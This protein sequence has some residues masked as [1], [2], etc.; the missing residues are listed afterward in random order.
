MIDL[1][2]QILIAVALDLLI[3]DP[4]WL[5]HPVK[6]IGRLA[7]WLES[8]SRRLIA[9]ARLAGVVT[10]L[11][12]I[13]ISGSVAWGL[14]WAAACLHPLAGNTVSIL[15][16][17]TCIAARDLAAHGVAVFRPLN[18]GNLGEARRRVAMIVGRDTDRLDES[19]V[20]RA[21]VESI[22]ENLVDGV[23]APLLFATIFGPVGAIVFKA[24]NTLDSTFGYKNE[25]YA[26]FGWASARID[27]V[28]NFLPARLTT[29]FVALAALLLH[30]RPGGA[31][32]IARRDRRRHTS[33]NAGYPEAAFAGALGVQLGGPSFYFGQDR[34]VQKPLIG[35]RLCELRAVHICKANRLMIATT[36]LFLVACVGARMIG[37]QL[38][39]QGGW[40]P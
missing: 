2:Y 35:D 38:W 9:S 21:T 18:A 15:L 31:L 27:D 5:P 36:A 30:E 32:R 25:Q 33:P 28:V 3:G 4:R 19:G 14:V 29:P 22:A 1:E 26:Q 16:I 34:P 40:T 20:A 17:Y 11:L 8:P 24:I 37:Q 10:A 7:A 6:L 23:T 39:Q 13:A 12:V